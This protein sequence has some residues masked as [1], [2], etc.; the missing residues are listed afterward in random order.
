MRRW[1]S[2]ISGPLVLLGIY[3]ALRVL[4]ASLTQDDGLLTPESLPNLGVAALGGVVL[5]LRLVVL[6]VLPVVVVFRVV[7]SAR[8]RSRPP[9]RGA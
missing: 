6:F 3:L 5:L 8:R 1:W 7:T 2:E 9:A 4:F